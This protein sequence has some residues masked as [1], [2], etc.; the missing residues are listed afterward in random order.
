MEKYKDTKTYIL[1]DLP[2][3]IELFLNHDA[4]KNI[5]SLI[6]K[7]FNMTC[8]AMELFDATYIY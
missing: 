7:K 2:G 4:L 1:F 8:C 6:I 3:Q 5:I